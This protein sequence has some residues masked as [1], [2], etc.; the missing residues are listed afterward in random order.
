MHSYDPI[1]RKS[2]IPF[3]SIPPSLRQSNDVPPDNFGGHFV[4]LLTLGYGSA[5][6]VSSAPLYTF[7][8]EVKAVGLTAK[9]ITRRDYCYA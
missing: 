4:S 6:A 8:G 2:S 9:T 3:A 7:Y 5:K 1:R